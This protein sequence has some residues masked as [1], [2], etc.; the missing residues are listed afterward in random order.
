[1]QMQV[2]EQLDNYFYTDVM[3]RGKYPR[4]MT[5]YFEENHI[6]LSMEEDD[7]SVLKAHTSDFLAF[8]YYMSVVTA[9]S[10]NNVK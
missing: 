1:M 7:V 3:I 6:S 9:K 4:Y 8:S 10:N 5:R 2:D